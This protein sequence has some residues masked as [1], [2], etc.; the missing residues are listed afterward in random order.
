LHYE[1][2][3]VIKICKNGKHISLQNA[4]QYYDQV[5]LGIDFTARDIQNQLKEKGLPWEKAKAFDDSAIVGKW[6]KFTPEMKDSPINFHFDVNSETKQVGSTTNMIFSIDILLVEISKYFSVNIG[7]LIFTGTPAGVGECVS[8][9][10]LE[11][12]FENESLLKLNV[13]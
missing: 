5:T 7:D 11:A 12:F 3:L 8:G 1:C 4:N 13:K 2:E 10:T 6:K 9:D